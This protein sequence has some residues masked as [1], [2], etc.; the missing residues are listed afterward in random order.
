M[1]VT[2][3]E[4]KLRL[5]LADTNATWSDADTALYNDG[6]TRML[7]VHRGALG[8]APLVDI[9]LRRVPDASLIVVHDGAVTDVARR[10]AERFGIR[11]LDAATLPEPT[12]AT[13]ELLA[14]AFEDAPATV[15]MLAEPAPVVAPVEVAPIVVEV[16]LVADAP[17]V[18][19]A[20]LLAEPP[21]A[22]PSRD[23]PWP[24]PGLIAG[25]DLAPWTP[26][27]PLPAARFFDRLER[28]EVPAPDFP[29]PE[30]TFFRGLETTELAA[31]FP[32]PPEAF[33]D[34]LDAVLVQQALDG[35]LE[36]LTSPDAPEPIAGLLPAF[37]EP[38]MPAAEPATV[39]AAEPVVA[40]DLPVPEPLGLPYAETPVTAEAPVIED[41]PA[42]PW[43]VGVAPTEPAA[44][45]LVEDHEVQAMPW[46]A[47]DHE[48]TTREPAR[49]ETQPHPT[50]LFPQDATWGLPWPRPVAPSDGLSIADPALWN[51]R[52]R[53]MG[54][55]DGLDQKG[56]PS[57]GAVTPEG[58]AWLRRL[59]TQLG[60]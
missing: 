21:L 53:M 50:Q 31:D 48:I 16:P 18:V 60:P 39:L 55:R 9:H 23:F 46:N 32:E 3:I 57:F 19:E 34:A 6:A 7:I 4:E 1:H 52:E 12:Y 30:A 49:R 25:L 59:Q 5:H 37:F 20:A 44:A 15:G 17:L 51:V 54:V 24:T 58:S 45:A 47:R 10:T 14:P 56:A 35:V 8:A 41:A 38:A 43:A 26:D 2:T 29:L 36:E 28:A 33:F 40:A 22:A 42:L 13:A 11:L 27:F